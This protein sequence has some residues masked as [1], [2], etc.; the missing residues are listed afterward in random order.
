MSYFCCFN[1][2]YSE[3]GVER[4]DL[5]GPDC[6]K[7]EPDFLPHIIMEPT[8]LETFLYNDFSS[9]LK[10]QFPGKKMQKIAVNAGFSCPNRDGTKG[11][12]GCTY[13]NNQTFNPAYCSTEKTV[14][15]Q[16]E[17]GKKFFSRKYPA[18]QYLA[19][20]QAY[21]NTY[22]TLD[23]LRAC[24]QEALSVPGVAG[25]VIGT[26]PDCVSPALLDY[27]AH[28]RKCGI[29]VLLEFGIESVFDDTLLR[30]NRG[31]TFSDTR[32]AIFE[33][34]GREIPVGGHL[35]LG[36]PG[37]DHGR[38]IQEAE[39]LSELPLTLLKLHQLQLIKGTRMAREYAENPQWFH[40]YSLQEYLDLLLDFI[41]HL[42]PDLVLERFVSQSP[43][44]LLAWPGWGVKNFEFTDM[45]RKQMK[46]KGSYQG[47]FYKEAQ[48]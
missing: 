21:T 32:K 26:R 4:T 17:E 13:C 15:E 38:L 23:R 5:S 36:L 42:R 18:M 33:A 27:L 46:E 35:I 34:A 20:F 10:Q 24:Y 22:G 40:R 41:A 28:L 19:Y 45:L 47:K 30:I 8:S 9:W 44:E 31:H 11:W 6:V 48:R 39:I 25:L 7:I 3:W 16:L 1:H 2:I 37:E 12:G 43:P 14:T 29:F